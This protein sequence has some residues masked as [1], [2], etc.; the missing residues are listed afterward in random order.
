M[1]SRIVLEDIQTSGDTA[2]FQAE[3]TLRYQDK[4]ARSKLEGRATKSIDLIAQATLDAIQQYF[5]GY[6]FKVQNVN[7]MKVNSH[8]I[9][10]VLVNI[11]QTEL[12]TEGFEQAGIAIG[13]EDLHL[14]IARATLNALNRII[15]RFTFSE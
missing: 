2:Q 5:E 7:I 6:E 11:K 3:I 12:R 13:K 8:E 9:V 10:I 14:A 4:I 1:E 15:G